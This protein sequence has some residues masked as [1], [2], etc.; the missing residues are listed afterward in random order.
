MKTKLLYVT[1]FVLVLFTSCS[2]EE[3]VV[4]ISTD[5]REAT[6][7]KLF[8]SFSKVAVGST[9]YT[10]F[11]QSLQNK[12]SSDAW[13]EEEIQQLE[14]EFLSQQSS[15][16]VQLYYYVVRLNL[17]EEELRSIIIDYAF[18]L[19]KTAIEKNEKGMRNNSDECTIYE[20]GPQNSLLA[21]LANILCEISSSS[22][23]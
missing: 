2:I 8:D 22:G 3:D 4:E 14:L 13:T 17:S 7:I 12:S 16:F 9:G 1:S 5:E 21:I 11:V 19:N 6:V 10:K 23:N 15:E 18:L 20:N